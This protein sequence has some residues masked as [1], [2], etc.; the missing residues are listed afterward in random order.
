MKT[1]ANNRLIR[2]RNDLLA[3]ILIERND[4]AQKGAALGQATQV[5]DKIRGGIQHIKS[6]PEILLLPLAVLFVS[7]TRRLWA[8]GISGVGLWRMLRNWRHRILS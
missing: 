1:A 7:R 3:Q 6:H 8:L 2:Q 5:I 4:L